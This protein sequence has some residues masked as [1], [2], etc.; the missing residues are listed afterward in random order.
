MVFLQSLVV[1]ETVPYD[2][3]QLSSL[4]AY[5]TWGVKGDS[6][7]GFRGPCDIDFE[8]MIDLEDVLSKSAIYSPDMLHFI[9]EHFDHD[10]E[11]GVLRQRLLINI[12]KEILEFHGIRTLRLGDDLY[13][14]DGKLSISIA[15]VTPVST[16]IHAGLNVSRENIPVKASCLLEAGLAE[17][18]IL[19][20]AEEICRSYA[21][22]IESIFLARCKVR[23]GR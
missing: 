16:M 4:W 10:L 20:L 22:E 18:Q 7:I 8:D 23:G 1:P 15:T 6:I 17:N 19:P 21:G 12:I 11:K 14:D 9:V 5:R 13:I 3:K 2:G